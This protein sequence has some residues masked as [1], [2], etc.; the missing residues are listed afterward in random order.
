LATRAAICQKGIGSRLKRTTRLDWKE[1]R[2]TTPTPFHVRADFDGDSILDDGW[3]LLATQGRG[4]GL[5][6]FFGSSHGSPRVIR[7]EVDE[8]K[9]DAQ[10]FG[11]ALAK[12]GQ[13]KTACGKGYWACKRREPQVLNLR[14]FGIEFFQFESSSSIFWWN[15]NAKKFERAW[16]S[17]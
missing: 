11:V 6:V 8:G 1:F 3:I 2:A 4:W 13:H 7:L 10:S 5:F 9:N 17:D 14:V 12:P 16:I 15:R